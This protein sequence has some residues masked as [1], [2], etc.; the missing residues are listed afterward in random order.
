MQIIV[1]VGIEKVKQLTSYA[2]H[3]ISQFLQSHFT[4][5]QRK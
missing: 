2:L 5:T 1:G 3:V 4:M